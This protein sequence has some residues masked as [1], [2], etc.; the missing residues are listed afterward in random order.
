[1]PALTTGDG[2]YLSNQPASVTPASER[3]IPM[4]GLAEF[5]PEQEAA[6]AV[7]PTIYIVESQERASALRAAIAQMSAQRTT[8]G[9]PPLVTEVEWFA[10]PEVEGD[11][12]AA[13]V[14]HQMSAG[15]WLPGSVIDLRDSAG[16]AAIDVCGLAA[17]P[18]D[19]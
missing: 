1:M 16:R 14:A 6:R 8:Q 9:E 2:H 17:A 10:S 7:T 15:G 13:Y 12:W 5:Y 11:F 4:G 18:A 19:C 3:A